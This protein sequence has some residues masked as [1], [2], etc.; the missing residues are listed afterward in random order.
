M[1]SR[2][3]TPIIS[4]V[5]KCWILPGLCYSSGAPAEFGRAISAP[6][7]DVIREAVK[8][9]T[10]LLHRKE[11]RIR[12]Y[13]LVYG[14]EPFLRSCKFCSYSRTSQHFMEREG[15]LSCSQEPSIAPYS[16]P[17][18]SS[19]YPICIQLLPIHATCPAHLILLDLIILIMFGDEY[20]LWSSS[21]CSFLQSL[22]TKYSPQH[23][24]LKHPPSM[25]L[26]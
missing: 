10:V 3:S 26:P 24:V 8:P 23:P 1:N 16:A 5:D 17:H 14:A 20:K 19:P 25:F 12:T 6:G 18:W 13:L 11:L 22:R 15:S 21:L 7:C 2:T 4:F 9:Y